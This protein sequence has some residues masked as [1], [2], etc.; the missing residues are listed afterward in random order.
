ME[1]EGASEADD[2]LRRGVAANADEQ[3]L[4][5]AVLAYSG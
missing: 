1:S 5:I 4:N 2:A 3:P